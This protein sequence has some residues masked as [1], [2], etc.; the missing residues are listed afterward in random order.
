LPPDEFI[1]LAEHSGLIRPLT[2]WVLDRA[3]SQCAG[4]HASGYP[5]SVA[6]NLSAR[7]L[8]E[9][10]LPATIGNLLWEH[11]LQPGYLALEITEG[12]IMEDPERAREII[13]RLDSMG[14]RIAID[15]FGTGYS[16]LAYLKRLPAGEI[17]ID[18]S[19]VMEMDRDREDAVIVR[20]TIELAHSLGRP[21]VAEGVEND[22]VRRELEALG[23]DFG[24]GYLFSPPL[25]AG[26]FEAWL[27]N[28]A[29]SPQDAVIPGAGPDALDPGE[30]EGITG[31]S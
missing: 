24:Q 17:K 7:N 18:K 31:L 19:F 3:I 20:S 16:S 2:R 11:G 25:P 22:L 4:W 23:C 29:W 14:I 21:V 10:E 8:L 13:T 27:C 28:S 15:D 6:V 9:D 26:E 1:G 5:L 12:L 30:S